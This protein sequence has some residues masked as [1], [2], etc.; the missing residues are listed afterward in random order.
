[1]V[2]HDAVQYGR[3]QIHRAERAAETTNKTI[4]SEKGLQSQT[5]WLRTLF[6]GLKMLNA[7][8]VAIYDG[9][10]DVKR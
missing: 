5:T 6:L 9:W 3:E 7:S 2:D 8:T 1:M 10:V 4:P